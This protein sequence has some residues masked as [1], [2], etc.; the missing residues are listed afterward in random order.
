MKKF[1]V[2]MLL[3][4]V[5]ASVLYTIFLVLY[6]VYSPFLVAKNFKRFVGG[7]YTFE[8]LKEARKVKDVDVL[9][10]G[11]SHAYRGY[12]PRIF[13]QDSLKAFNL[14]SSSQSPLQTEYMVKKF[15]KGFNPKFVIVDVYPVLIGSDGVESQLDLVSNGLLDKDI[16]LTSFGINDIRLYNTLIFN[17]IDRKFHFKGKRPKVDFDTYVPGGFVQSFRS[18][19]A[20][21][22]RGRRDIKVSAKQMGALRSI[23]KRLKEDHIPYVIVQTPF[24]KSNYNTYKNNDQL[25]KLF[26]EL[27]EYYNFNKIMELPDSMYYDD[28]HLNQ[29]GVNVFNRKL[30]DTLKKTGHFKGISK[31]K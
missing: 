8:R 29:Y 1:I 20:K 11:S 23:V 14:G 25:D 3:F 16:V 27:G 7:G 21:K 19:K 17:A 31:G 2:K 6:G 28:S 15:L 12:D 24:P 22:K 30:I 18:V 4:A 10:L 9:I 26:S 13:K 5:F